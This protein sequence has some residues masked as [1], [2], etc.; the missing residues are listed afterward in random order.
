M[1]GESRRG[2]T[3]PAE[4]DDDQKKSLRRSWK[5]SGPVAK[6]TVVFAGIAA[7]ATVTYAIIA[8][9]QLCVMSGQLDQ[10]RQSLAQNQFANTRELRP[11]VH[12]NK[13][14]LVGELKEGQ[15]F[16]GRI[17]I[18][19]SGRTP[20]LKL[21]GCADIAIKPNSDPMTDDFPCPAPNNPGARLQPTGEHSIF[22][23]GSGI[24]FTLMSPGTSISPMDKL[25][26]ILSTGGLRLYLYGDISYSDLV[27][28]EVVHRT[29]FCGR[30]NV[31]TRSFDV[32]EKHNRMD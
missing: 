1:G 18:T 31:A 19:N 9:W 22:A 7:A 26:P 13:F 17:E 6:L 20:A 14:D 2:D 32:C 11:Y 29:T 30:Y 21:E 28:P 12:A 8:G 25:L 10:M 16:Q 5:S 3:G 15:K 24:P 4:S 23:L 27:A